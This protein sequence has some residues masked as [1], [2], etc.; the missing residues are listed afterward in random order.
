MLLK[1]LKSKFPSGTVKIWKSEEGN[2]RVFYMNP[3]DL[4]GHINQQDW[5]KVKRWNGICIYPS[6]KGK[7][8]PCFYFYWG[9]GGSPEYI[10]HITIIE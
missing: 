9:Y 2:K 6:A 8:N 4:F 5:E 3:D 7:P 10:E 1:D